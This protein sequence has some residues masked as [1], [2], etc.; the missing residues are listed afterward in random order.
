MINMKTTEIIHQINTHLTTNPGLD[1]HTGL[2]GGMAGTLLY[3]GYHSYFTNVDSFFDD[4]TFDILI[5]K[6][7]ESINNPMQPFI[8][9][10]GLTGELWTLFNLQKLEYLD[11][12]EQVFTFYKDILNQSLI[13][14]AKADLWD[15]LHGAFGILYYLNYTNT[16]KKNTL[17]EFLSLYAEKVYSKKEFVFYATKANILSEELTYNLS[18]SH[19]LSGQV[20][21]FSYLLKKH[22]DNKQLRNLLNDMVQFI[23]GYRCQSDTMSIFPSTLSDLKD[24]PHPEPCRLA[25]CYGDLGTG[26]ALYRYSSQIKDER[27]FNMSIKI[28]ETAAKRRGTQENRV[29]DAPLC[30]GASGIMQTFHR[31]HFET[32]NSIFKDATDYWFEETIKFYERSNSLEMMG[33]WRHDSKSFLPVAGLLEG[34]A[35]I[36]L[37][38]LSKEHPEIE[39][40]WDGCLFLS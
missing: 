15:N 22:P 21:I 17:S 37:V 1:Q 24:I 14:N 18:L 39:P 5:D 9:S 33:A 19:G 28:L 2:Y 7:F 30:H 25:W 16:L 35:G 13:A 8:F 23:L 27:L 11:I 29:I 4:K 32:N 36:S 34:Y 40:K 26:F 20:L 3:T 6:I 38:L 12:D 31:L 10:S